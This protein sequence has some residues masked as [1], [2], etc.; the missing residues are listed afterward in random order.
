MT[1][2]HHLSQRDVH[3]QKLQIFVRHRLVHLQELQVSQA[4]EIGLHSLQVPQVPLF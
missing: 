4:L 3:L 1:I 2:Q